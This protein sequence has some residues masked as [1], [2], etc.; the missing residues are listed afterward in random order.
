MALHLACQALKNRECDMAFVAGVNLLLRSWHYRYFCS[1]SALSP[2]GRCH[3][4]DSR[5][6]GY[7]PGEAIAAILLKPLSKAQAD[8]DRIH[9]I[10]KGSAIIMVVIRLL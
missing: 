4:F 8:G 10:I 3:T 9:A 6:D 1:I 5:A 2:T 7:V